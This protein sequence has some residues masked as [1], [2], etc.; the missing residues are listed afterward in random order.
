MASIKSEVVMSKT[1]KFV[2]SRSGDWGKAFEEKPILGFAH[3][4]CG[5]GWKFRPNNAA[6]KPSRKFHPTLEACLP[7]W[8]KLYYPD[9]SESR[10]VVR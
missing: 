6:H 1:V 7:R 3:Y 2:R 10:E 5:Q 4:T 8:M 9:G